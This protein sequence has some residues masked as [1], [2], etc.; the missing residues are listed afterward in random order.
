MS[1]TT[2]TNCPVKAANDIL[3]WTTPPHSASIFGGGLVALY[4]LYSNTLLGLVSNGLFFATSIACLWVLIKNVINAFQQQQGQTVQA[5][6]PFQ[7]ALDSIPNN[8]NISEDMA[9][10]IAP[11]IAGVVNCFISSAV[12]LV[13]VDSW[14][15][16]M[17]LVVV[18]YLFRGMLQKHELLCL[19]SY[20]TVWNM[21]KQPIQQTAYFRAFIKRQSRSFRAIFSSSQSV[22]TLGSPLSLCHGYTNSNKPKSMRF[23]LK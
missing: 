3:M 16:S 19:I 10:K 18:L 15:N 2:S 7:F 8:F 13:L 14:A 22:F 11:K 17:G 20:R 4:L 12:K 6:H 5:Q 23:S 1:S 21:A 9:M